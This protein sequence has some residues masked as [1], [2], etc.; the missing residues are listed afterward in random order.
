M[1]ELHANLIAALRRD[2]GE[3]LHVYPDSLGWL[4][5]GVGRL[6]DKRKGGGIS[7]VE[8]AYLLHNDIE[9]IQHELQQR[10]PWIW[11][12]G[13]ARIGVWMNLAFQLGVEGV[14]KFER[15]L[16]LAEQGKYDECAAEMLRS[17]WRLQTPE[18]AE[19]MARQMRSSE[20][21]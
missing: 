6:V 12:L 15:A 10:A 16:L 13:E 3:V 1:S 17:Q 4:T 11:Q 18:R 9:H 8:S 19:R 7:K 2:E 21:Q 14:M 5:I 20:W